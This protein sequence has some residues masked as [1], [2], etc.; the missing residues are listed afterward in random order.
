MS[1]NTKLHNVFVFS[2]NVT[3]ASVTEPNGEY[4]NYTQV[5]PTINVKNNGDNPVTSITVSYTCGDISDEQ[6]FNVNIEAGETAD[7]TFNPVDVPEGEGSISFIVRLVNGGEN[8]IQA[9]KTASYNIIH[10]GERFRLSLTADYNDFLNPDPDETSWDIKDAENNI[11]YRGTAGGYTGSPV[12]TEFCF[13]AGCYTFNLYDS[14]GNGLSGTYGY[15]TGSA[16]FT[17]LNTDE[18]LLTVGSERFSTK[19]VNFCVGGSTENTIETATEMSIYPNPTSGMLNVISNE[20]IDSVE[21]FNSVG[22]AVFSSQVACN[23]SEIDMSNLPNGMYFVRVY[24]ANGI[25][26]VKVV[27]ER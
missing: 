2:G 10:N 26:T 19:T 4:C 11:L 20:E 12:I 27:L 3:I 22:T 14:N 18:T 1:N 23:S 17:N 24:T 8:K 15:G 21:I 7:I 6:T 16:S 25:E 5:E 13:G 9:P